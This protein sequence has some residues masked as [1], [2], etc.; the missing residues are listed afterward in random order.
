[1]ITFVTGNQNKLKEVQKIL[2]GLEVTNHKLDLAEMQGSYADIT[3]YKARAAAEAVG[4]PAVVD[5]TALEFD[6]FGKELP[7]PYIKWFLDQLGP[8]N[9][10]KML[11]GFENK[12]GS[13]VCSVGYCAG[14][15]QEPKVFTA[16]VP[17][18]IV[19]PRGPRDFG[20]DSCFL[21]NGFDQT[22]AEMD[23]SLKNQISHRGKAFGQLKEFLQK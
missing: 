19:Y 15:G 14:P 23:K 9:L 3:S 10:P 2:S 8:D 13:A 6:A 17:G 11:E 22:Y 20:W 16:K 5:D 21:P 18:Q 12:N 1:M 4:G 7:G